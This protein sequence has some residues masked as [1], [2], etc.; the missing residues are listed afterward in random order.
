[1][2]II[3][4]PK[5]RGYPVIFHNVILWHIW[6]LFGFISEVMQGQRNMRVR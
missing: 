6:G 1:M 2:L 3:G 4:V 5:F